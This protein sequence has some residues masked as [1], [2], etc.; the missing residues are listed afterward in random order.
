MEQG[1]VAR[2]K[3]DQ[4]QALTSLDQALLLAVQEKEYSTAVNIL[5]QHLLVFKVRYEQTGDDTFMELLYADV[6]AGLRLCDHNHIAGQPKS[7]MLLRGGDYFLH[8]RDYATA[9]E[10]YGMAVAE[11][12]KTSREPEETL[13][14]Y[15]GYW[16]NA[17][18]KNGDHTAFAKFDEALHILEEHH[19]LRPFHQLI[20]ES[21]ILLRQADAYN[22]VGQKD[23]A[24]AIWNKAK[25][26][27]DSIASEHG[28]NMRQKQA[29]KL[30]KQIGAL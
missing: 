11:L 10:Q 7:V 8:K 28:M 29:E 9:A 23:K 17:L 2:E 5:G 6:L 30:G 26:I 21:G 19:G 1:E 13:A 15:I 12:N 22:F 4:A 18:V 16:A 14:E 24:I 3:G 25:Q 27:A 20:V